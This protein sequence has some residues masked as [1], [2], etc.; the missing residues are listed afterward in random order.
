VSYPSLVWC[1]GIIAL[2]TA[3]VMAFGRPALAAPNPVV[4]TV[5]ILGKGAD[6]VPCAST[7]EKLKAVYEAS[8]NHDDDGVQA[9][10][11]GGTQLVR[12]ERV[13]VIDN[14][15]G[16]GIMEGIDVRVRIL[17]GPD[18]HLACWAWQNELHLQ[19]AK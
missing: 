16:S 4:G 12:G 6:G 1:G 8:G 17:T 14:A 13:L 10:L 9:A 3:S 15:A 2:S 7:R 19:P 18:A 5:A 11:Q